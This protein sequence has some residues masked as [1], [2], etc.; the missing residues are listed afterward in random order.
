MNVKLHPINS[1]GY[2]NKS[3]ILGCSWFA[4]Y[5]VIKMIFT[6]HFECK[7]LKFYRFFTMAASSL[8]SEMGSSNLN[9]SSGCD[10][11]SLTICSDL[12][13][14]VYRGM[15][16]YTG[17]LSSLGGI[18]SLL[19]WRY[20]TYHGSGRKTSLDLTTSFL[21]VSE[22]K[23]THGCVA[24]VFTSKKTPGWR[25]LYFTRRPSKFIHITSTV[26]LLL[27]MKR[28]ND[29]SRQC[30][31]LKSSATTLSSTIVRF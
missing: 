8:C 31:D 23:N 30:S 4:G 27:L 22:S 26:R 25:V 12:S 2:A 3:H 10:R 20:W 18:S 14:S 6:Q 11:F 15:V 7:T 19:K 1:Y 29:L 9:A 13:R 28:T 21:C 17:V 16:I 24:N 5:A